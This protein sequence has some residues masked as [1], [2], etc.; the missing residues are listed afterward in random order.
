MGIAITA[1]E[2]WKGFSGM[3]VLR[4]LDLTVDAGTVHCLLG[5]NG[6]G[7]TTLLSLM[8]TLARP[9]GGSIE[10]FGNDTLTAAERV[11]RDICVTGQAAAVDE[12]LTGRENLMLFGR[13]LGLPRARAVRRARA[14]LHTF[15]IDGDRRASTYSGGQRR[16]LDLALSLIR[17]PRVLFLDEPTTGLDLGSRRALWRAVREVRDAGTTVVLT[18]Q[19]LEEAAQLADV[20]SVLHDGVITATGSPA[21]LMAAVGEERIELIT[22]DGTVLD[23]RPTNAAPEA[24]RAGLDALIAGLRPSR[25][26]SRATAPDGGTAGVLDVGDLRVRLVRPSM[27]DVYLAL[28]SGSPVPARAGGLP[29]STSTQEAS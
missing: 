11:R 9:D 25:A 17:R 19:Y 29:A 10:V 28:T 16:R 8:S 24:V 20:V 15:A 12:L 22:T 26:S 14:L 1:T 5:E 4:G 27:D 6:A 13:L 2:V 23:S 18:T 21:D 7:K 3:P